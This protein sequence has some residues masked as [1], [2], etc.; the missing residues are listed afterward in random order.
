[1][2]QLLQ[3]LQR[4]SLVRIAVAYVVVGWILIQVA[5]T[6]LPTFNAP[7]WVQQVFV[8]FI[9]MGFPLALVLGWAF[10]DSGDGDDAVPVR[11]TERHIITDGVLVFLMV[12]LVAIS[13]VGQFTRAPVIVAAEPTLANASIAVLAFDDLSAGGTQAHF[14][15]GIS[16]EILNALAQVPDLRVA[17][18]TSSFSFRGANATAQDIGAALNVA[19]IL[20]GSVRIAGDNMR[21]TAQLIDTANGFH[22][23]SNN[24]NRRIE[25]IFAIQDEVTGLILA[26][27]NEE[28]G[29]SFDVVEH[30]Q[31]TDNVAAY[32][33]YFLGRHQMQQRNAEAMRLAVS[34]YEQAISLDGQYADAWAGL[35]RAYYLN[36][37]AFTDEEVAERM[38][39][40]LA[41]AIALDPDNAVAIATLALVNLG[42]NNEANRNMLE[43]MILARRALELAPDDIEIRMSYVNSLVAA[44]RYRDAYEEIQAILEID[45]GFS[46]AL[47]NLMNVYY[48][49]KRYDLAYPMLQQQADGA[50]LIVETTGLYIGLGFTAYLV[51][52]EAG[53]QHIL[54]MFEGQT[55]PVIVRN[56]EVLRAGIAGFDGDGGPIVEMVED[57]RI[58]ELPSMDPNWDLDDVASIYAVAGRYD[59]AFE[60]FNQAFDEGNFEALYLEIN[61]IPIDPA[62]FDDPRWDQLLSR[63]ETNEVYRLQRV[64]EEQGQWEPLTDEEVGVATN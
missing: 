61:Q 48:A 14:A 20:E 32:N 15:E 28:M 26:A 25:D 4:R 47:S 29:T 30:N 62:F 39:P 35:G 51:G 8:L 46:P 56:Y 45:P 49:L 11:V 58:D 60:L 17:A 12:V 42:I 3:E 34:A 5:D 40:A 55:D 57:G 41:E 44:Q 22:V 43:G 2:Q 36:Y 10:G 37:E 6:I 50:P 21:I 38:R 19:Y 18:R 54:D 23:W 7:G 63:P 27:L 24:Y 52:D 33:A 64:A 59:R 9:V 1:M 31:G 53:L 16:E 13:T